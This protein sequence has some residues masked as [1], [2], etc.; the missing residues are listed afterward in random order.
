MML[1]SGSVTS[2]APLAISRASF[3]CVVDAGCAKDT[4]HLHIQQGHEGWDPMDGSRGVTTRQIL[5]SVIASLLRFAKKVLDRRRT[6]KPNI[7]RL[8]LV[9]DPIPQSDVK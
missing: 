3:S 9:S 6:N 8:V 5:Q 1:L 2:S 7:D 4:S